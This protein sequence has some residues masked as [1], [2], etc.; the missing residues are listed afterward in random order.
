MSFLSSLIP[1]NLNEEKAKFFADQTYNPQFIYS[2]EV[3]Q[4]KLNECGKSSEK[5]L[6]IA[7][8]I[9]QKAYAGRTESDLFLM[10]GSIVTQ[11]DVEKTIHTFLQMHKLEKR[12]KT[13]W[14]SSYISRATIT[15]DLIKLRLPADFRKEGL[16]GMLYHEVGTHALRRLNYEEQPWYKKKKKF[17][18]TDYL[19]TEEG[20]ATLHAMIPHTNKSAFISAIRYVAV[21][22][23]QTSSFAE[24]WNFLKQYI[25]DLERRWMVTLRQKRGLEDTRKPGGYT[26]D[27]VYFEGM[28]DVYKWLEKNNFNITNLYFGKLALEDAAKAVELNPK[29]T[30]ILPSFFTINPE[31]YSQEIKKIGEVNEL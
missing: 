2:E 6:Q 24:T 5:Y 15:S 13:S 21:A 1:I 17:G 8:N 14:S 20:L 23:A 19:K 30:P 18:F 25:D 22:K 12:F 10:E 3:D 16:L 4:K 28:V 29:F 26:K 27:L 31:N 11:K 9:L 7:R